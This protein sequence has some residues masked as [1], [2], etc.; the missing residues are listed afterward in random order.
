MPCFKIKSY[1]DFAINRYQ[2]SINQRSLLDA[3]WEVSAVPE[4]QTVEGCS[5]GTMLSR[6]LRT[7][8]QNRLNEPPKTTTAALNFAEACRWE[9]FHRDIPM[10]RLVLCEFVSCMRCERI[11][12]LINLWLAI[13]F[14]LHY[15]IWVARQKVKACWHTGEKDGYHCIMPVCLLHVY[16]SS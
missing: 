2:A 14:W 7:L 4:V 5:A 6:A 15:K 3:R 8:I 11:Q 16:L 10:W 1:L 13:V 12:V 9:S